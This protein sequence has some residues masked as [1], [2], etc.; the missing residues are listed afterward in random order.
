MYKSIKVLP[1]VVLIFSTS[2]HAA[3][4][5]KADEDSKSAL[6]TGLELQ[7]E[8]GVGYDS[9]IYRAP[10]ES[11]INYADTCNVGT[12]P[13]CVD[14]NGTGYTFV[15][16]EIHSGIYIPAELDLEFVKGTSDKNFLITS[17]KFDGEFYADSKYNNANN[18]SHKFRFGDEFVFKS[19]G[20]KA[21]SIYVGGLLEHKKR[22]YLDRDT[23]EEQTSSGTAGPVGIGDR[24][25]YDAV[26]I[27]ADYKS[28]IRKLQYDVEFK[29]YERDY[30]DPVVVSQYDHTYFR[31]GGDI[32]Y[33][34]AKPTKLTVGY[35]YYTY[36]YSER[37]SR[38]ADG[39]LFKSNPTR[40]YEY[41]VIDFTL[42]QRLA[43]SW[44]MYLDYERK[45]RDDKYVGYDNYTKDLLKA[46]LHYEINK[47]N[48]IKLTYA[49]W[50]RDYPNAYA[51][52][53][54][55][56]GIQKQYDGTD[57]KLTST[58][59]LN[60]NNAIVVDFKYVDENTT[61]L[62]YDYDRYKVFVSYQWEK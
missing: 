58:T 57:I 1:V 33:Q 37:P 39:K 6:K 59:K 20:S 61:D 36:D 52:D 45:T 62:R 50:E 31:L 19:V 46:R 23:G 13:D 21:N 53:N 40:K 4:I 49:Y 10:G 55:A 3:K 16:P 29:L 30:E 15:D 28:R 9:N 22:L 18:Y 7:V 27:E 5:E 47:N 48:K 14:V 60:K 24:Y 8:A 2:T 34:I 44:L 17:Y 51:F 54:A 11:Y 43:K 35:K 26:G 56:I 32:K 41:N 12:D 42:R 25:T 38:D